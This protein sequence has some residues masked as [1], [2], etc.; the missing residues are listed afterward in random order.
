MASRLRAG[1][2]CALRAL[3]RIRLPGRP[4][5]V[6]VQSASRVL[7]ARFRDW[8][9]RLAVEHVSSQLKHEGLPRRPAF[10]QAR[11]SA[12][13]APALFE[14]TSGGGRSSG[15]VYSPGTPFENVPAPRFIAMMPSAASDRAF[16]KTAKVA[17]LA[18]SCLISI[19][20]LEVTLR[21]SGRVHI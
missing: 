18:G 7:Y 21:W 6:E 9:D 15:A 13:P 2:W 20:A 5:S 12:T 4:A 1:L 10:G 8:H 16:N 11:N 14:R 3:S 17:A 19:L